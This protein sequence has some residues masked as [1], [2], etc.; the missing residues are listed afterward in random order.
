MTQ[1]ESGIGCYCSTLIIVWYGLH[2]SYTSKANS[3]DPLGPSASHQPDKPGRLSGQGDQ[4]PETASP[5]RE[6]NVTPSSDP[7]SGLGGGNGRPDGGCV[8]PR[9]PESHTAAA[10][11][12]DTSRGISLPRPRL[13]SLAQQRSTPSTRAATGDRQRQCR[14][15]NDSTTPQARTPSSRQN[16]RPLRGSSMLAIATQRVPPPP[17]PIPPALSLT[18]SSKRHGQ[19]VRVCLALQETTGYTVNTPARQEGR[20]DATWQRR[21]LSTG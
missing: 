14:R 20:L 4:K 10:T 1:R 15:H 18:V 3:V 2:I 8:Y 9:R 7:A 5:G 21:A 16:H 13:A 11:A 6:A 17:L 19:R 12:Q